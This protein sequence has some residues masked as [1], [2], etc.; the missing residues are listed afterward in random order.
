MV[1]SKKTLFILG[2]ITILGGLARFWH[3]TAVPPSLNWD[4]V[5]HAYNAYALLHTGRDQWG[6]VL[7][8][9]NFRAYG[10]YPTTLNLYF[11]VPAIALLSLGDWQVRFPHAL[12]GTLLIPLVFIAGYKWRKNKYLALWAALFVAID[13]WTLFPSRAIFQ[14]NW[15]VFLLGLALCLYFAKRTK[16]AILVWGLSL[17]AY[18]NTRIYVPMLL[19]TLAFFGR[20]NLRL[21]IVIIAIAGTILLMPSSRSRSAQVGLF[22]PA[23]VATIESLRNHSSLAPTMARLVYNRPVYLAAQVTKNYLGY[24]SPQ[25]LGISGGTQYQYSV[26]KY[27][28][29]PWVN[30]PFFY[31]GL[32]LL[33][34][35][36]PLVL[37]WLLLA[38][39]PAA[40]TQDQFA[41]I[42]A[43]TMLP[44]VQLVTALGAAWFFTRIPSKLRFT[45]IAI[46]L[47]MLATLTGVYLF[48]YSHTYTTDYSASWQ[49]GYKQT[50][51]FVKI[52]YQDYD[53]IVMSKRYAEPHEFVLWYWPWDSRQLL[54]DPKYKW[55]YHANWYW[56]DGFGKFKFVND[57][58]MLA[59]AKPVRGVRILVICSP[60]NIVPGKR[61]KEINFLNGQPAFIL[62]EI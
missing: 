16:S 54:T 56:V 6:Q 55:D 23:T 52:H 15:T 29:M 57:W 36:S 45:A 44:L 17:L 9:L 32:I 59:T 51:D 11:T 4:E 48:N 42:R 20:R 10:D 40:I 14:S 8:L 21:I 1:F 19:T 46:Y 24:F 13:P 39:L 38:P 58:E 22:G 30:L 60:D 43:T 53:Q 26:P 7:P 37:I 3:L 49:Y 18:H 35:I 5:S 47:V 50:I 61:V 41:V 28:L 62:V 12:V 34:P 27:G 31:L 2:L 33:I 25:F